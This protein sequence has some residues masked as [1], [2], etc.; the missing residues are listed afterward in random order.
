MFWFSISYFQRFFNSDE[1][2]FY[3]RLQSNRDFFNGRL[4]IMEKILAEHDMLP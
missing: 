1:T 2:K 4:E 3:E